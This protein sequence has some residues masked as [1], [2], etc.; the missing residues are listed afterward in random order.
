MKVNPWAQLLAYVTGLNNP[1]GNG[2]QPVNSLRTYGIL[3]NDY[4]LRW[5]AY[6]HAAHVTVIDCLASFRYQS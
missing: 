2:S 5:A 3:S 1:D 4:H 6:L